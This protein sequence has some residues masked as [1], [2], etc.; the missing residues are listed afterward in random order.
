MKSLTFRADE[1][2][3][4]K[5]NIIAAY[6]GRSTNRQLTELVKECVKKFEEENGEIVLKQK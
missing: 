3:I 1:H 5:L 6:E 4:T 2:L